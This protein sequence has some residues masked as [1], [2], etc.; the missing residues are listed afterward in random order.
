M[1]EYLSAVADGKHFSPS[2]ADGAYVQSVMLAAID[3]D[4]RGGVR[5]EV[6]S[7]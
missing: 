5:V 1:Y 2:L 6:P 4:R 3:S 7:P